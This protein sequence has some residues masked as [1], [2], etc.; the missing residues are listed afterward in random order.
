M[1]DA[2][3]PKVES[4]SAATTAVRVAP[5]GQPGHTWQAV[6]VENSRLRRAKLS[7]QNSL[8]LLLSTMSAKVG[9]SRVCR[10]DITLRHRQDM[11]Q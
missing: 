8:R 10:G 3:S 7:I 6:G 1:H 5:S 4:I 11:G 2:C 9:S